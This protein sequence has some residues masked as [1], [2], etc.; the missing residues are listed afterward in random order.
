MTVRK[1][2]KMPAV[3]YCSTC[4]RAVPLRAA[5]NISMYIASKNKY[6]NRACFYARPNKANHEQLTK[7]EAEL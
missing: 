4:K 6:C 3:R 7:L 5:D 2:R 1:Y